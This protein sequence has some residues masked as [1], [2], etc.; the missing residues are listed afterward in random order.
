EAEEKITNL[1]RDALRGE[2]C[3][4]ALDMF[5]AYTKK[6][7]FVVEAQV[8]DKGYIEQEMKVIYDEFVLKS[9]VRVYLYI[10]YNFRSLILTSSVLSSPGVTASFNRGTV[11]SFFR[12]DLAATHSYTLESGGQIELGLRK[13]IYKTLIMSF[14]EKF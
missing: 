8:D 9:S 2:R 5:E 3:D 12:D 10:V 13:E 1:L 7:F 11:K 6:G 14:L 4:L